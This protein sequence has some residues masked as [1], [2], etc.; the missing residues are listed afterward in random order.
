[1]T[2]TETAFSWFLLDFLG[3]TFLVWG[4]FWLLRKLVAPL[5]RSVLRG[6]RI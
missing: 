2:T 3:A 5:V 1:M 4:S 6:I